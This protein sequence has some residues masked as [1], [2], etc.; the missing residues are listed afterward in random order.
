MDSLLPTVVPEQPE[1]MAV[2]Q[3]EDVPGRPMRTRWVLGADRPLPFRPPSGT[4]DY[5]DPRQ[6]RSYV[7]DKALSSVSAAQPV[8]ND[9]FELA[10]S[11]VKYTGSDPNIDDEIEALKTGRS[12]TKRL[13]GQY[14]L[15]DRATG[16][17]VAKSGRKTLLNVPWMTSDGYYVVRGVPY[18][19]VT[20]FRMNPGI[21][22]RTASDGVTEAQFNTAQGFGVPFRVR[23]DPKTGVFALRIAGHSVPLYRVLSGMGIPDQAM[24]KAWGKQLLEVNR[25]KK[26]HSSTVAWLNHMLEAERAQ[27]AKA[28]PDKAAKATD[29][30]LLR[31]Y[32]S[33]MR[34]DAEGTQRLMGISYPEVSPESILHASLRV[35]NVAAGKEEQDSRDNPSNQRVFDFGDHL[36]TYMQLDRGGVFRSA[37][38]KLRN[39]PERLSRLPSALFDQHISHHLNSSGLAQT[40]DLINPLDSF[41]QR[42][43]ITRLGEGAIENLDSAP[44][45]AREVQSGY[46]GVIDS[47]RAPECYS[48]DTDVMTETGWKSWPSV[49]ESDR[50]ACLLDSRLSFEHPLRLMSYDY[51]GKLFC[52]DSKTLS[53][54][55]TPNHRMWVTPIS[56]CTW[57][58]E[59]AE[60]VYGRN[61]QVLATHLP[62]EPA[63]SEDSFVVPMC[64]ARNEGTQAHGDPPIGAAMRRVTEPI[65]MD[66]WARFMGY[67][68]SEGCVCIDED[69]SLFLVS[70]SQSKEC[71]PE[72]YVEIEQLLA[73]LPFHFNT[74][75]A[76]NGF[77]CHSKQLALYLAQFGKSDKKHVPEYLF[78]CS[79]SN[80]ALFLDCLLKGDGRA[81]RSGVRRTLCTIS[82]Q[83]TDDFARLQFMQGNNVTISFEKDKRAMASEGGCWAARCN[84]RGLRTI[85][86]KNHWHP[87][88][89]QHI[90]DYTGKVYCAEVPGGLLFVRRGNTSGFWCGNSLRIGLDMHLARSAVKG[91]DNQ[92]YTRLLDTK[93]GKVVWRT[94]IQMETAFIGEPGST[95]GKDKFVA[96]MSPRY[97]FQYVP[98]KDVQYELLSGDDLFS[99]ISDTIPMKSGVK[100]MR[101]LMG[102]KYPSY[103]VPLVTREAPLVETPGRDG[104]PASEFM[105]EAVGALRSPVAG[106]VVSAGARRMVI[107]TD[108]GQT[109][110]IEYSDWKPYARKTHIEQTPVPKKGDRVKPGSLLTVSNYTDQDG[111]LALGRNL[112]VGYMGYQGKNFEDAVVISESAARKLT[113][114]HTY[115]EDWEPGDGETS[116][117]GKFLALFPS[118]YSKDQLDKIGPDGFVKP[119]TEVNSGDP[120]VLAVKTRDPNVTTMGRRLH[121]DKSMVWEHD[122]PGIVR[123]V[124]KTR[125]GYRVYVESRHLMRVGDKLCY[126]DKTEVLTESGWK[127]FENLQESDRVACLNPTTGVFTYDAPVAVQQYDHTGKMYKIETQLLD[128]VVTDNHK[129]FVQKRRHTAFGLYTPAEIFGKRVS[130]AKSGKW[131]GSQGDV[132]DFPG[133]WRKTKGAG[134]TWM[135]GY[136][137]PVTDYMMLLGMFLSEGNTFCNVASGSYGIDINQ[138]KYVDVMLKALDASSIEYG[139]TA[140]G[141]RI[142]DRPLLEHF[143]PFGKSYEKRIPEWV[144]S[145]ASEHLA[146]L[147]RWLI[148]GDGSVK[149][150]R[151]TSYYTSSKGLADDVQRLCLHIGYAANVHQVYEACPDGSPCG[152]I[153][154]R[155]VYRRHDYYRVAIITKKTIPT[156][157]HGHVKKQDA[158]TEKWIDYSGK[159][160]CCS[161]PDNHVIYVRRNGKGAWCGNSNAFGG[162]GVVSE[163]VPDQE[164]V[165]DGEGRPLDII[166]SSKGIASRTNPAQLHAALLGKI[167]SKTNTRYVLPG[168]F[169]EDATEFVEKELADNGISDTEDLFDPRSGKTVPQVMTGVLHFYKMQQMAEA[170]G[171]ARDTGGYSEDESPSR[172]SGGSSSKH[173]G[174]MEYSS[175]LAHGA[176]NVL[177]DLKTVHGQYNPE[178][179]R[180]IKLGGTPSVPR[181]PTVYDKFRAMVRSSGVTLKE[182]D[183]RG[184]SVFASTDA[185]VRELT[186]DR[187]ITSAETYDRK[188]RPIPGGLFDPRATSSTTTGDRFAYIALPEPL[189]NPHMEGMARSL[190][191]L[192]KVD[193]DDIV[194]GRREVDG[195]RGGE[196]L[197]SMLE[198]VD[199]ARVA[200]EAKSILKSEGMVSKKDAAAK[201]LMYAEAMMVQKKQPS[202]FMMTRV[203]VLPPKFRRIVMQDDRLVVPDLNY[204]YR[205]LLTSIGDFNE[206][207]FLGEDLRADARE[208]M[209][210]A[211][212]ALIGTETPKDK[213]L[214]AKRV[215]GV[216][217]Q[218][219]GK[220]SP[221]YSMT[222]RKVF[223]FNID[224]SALGVIVP[225]PSLKLNEVG[226]PED[227]A[228]TLFGP[229]VIRRLVEKGRGAT[230]AAEAVKNRDPSVRS[231]LTEVMAERPVLLN[232]APTLHKYG[233]MAV[234]AKTVPGKA[235]HINPQ[236]EGPFGADNDGD[237]GRFLLGLDFSRASGAVA[238]SGLEWV[239]STGDIFMKFAV[240]TKLITTQAV[241]RIC[242][243]P[244][245]PETRV[246]KGNGITEWKT[247]EWCAVYAYDPDTGV[248]RWY[249]ITALSLHAGKELFDVRI[250][251]HFSRVETVTNDHSL[252][253][254]NPETGEVEKGRPADLVGKLV[255]SVIRVHDHSE[256]FRSWVLS[257]THYGDPRQVELPLNRACGQVLGMIL[258]NGWVSSIDQLC[259]ASN[260]PETRAALEKALQV[261]GFPRTS[262][263]AEIVYRA[264]SLGKN[265]EGERTRVVVH[266]PVWFNRALGREIGKGAENKTIPWWSLQAPE[267]HLL[268]MLEG[269]LSTDGTVSL[270]RKSNG[271]LSGVIGYDTVSCYLRDAVC[272]LCLRLGLR[273]SVS[274]YRGKHSTTDCYRISISSLDMRKL[275]RRCPDFTVYNENKARTLRELMGAV[276]ETC[277]VASALDRIPYPSAVHDKLIAIRQ[278]SGICSAATL[279]S[280]AK[281]GSMDRALASLFV[282]E[283]RKLHT[284]DIV[285]DRWTR[286]VDDKDIT[287]LE[288]VSVTPAGR[289]DCWDITVPGPYTFAT[290]A[291]TVMQDTMSMTVPVSR[292]AVQ[293]AYRK[294]LPEHNLIGTGSG[295]PHYSPSQEPL[296]ALYLMTRD[297]KPGKPVRT[298]ASMAEMREAYRKGEVD[299]DDP[300]RIAS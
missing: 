297:P 107:Q 292:A 130:Y 222:Q 96:A 69:K 206:A 142:Y 79:A 210:H 238:S 56:S 98:R 82:R 218:L 233:I 176:T 37:L 31:S 144:F 76:K 86:A 288:V 255:P 35:L 100:G 77:I 167:A 246:D 114:Q 271:K 29:T 64:L 55:V 166:L 48:A 240:G 23:M 266:T 248:H 158:Q 278:A 203:P 280:A 27:Q 85:Y 103:S 26:P 299:V 80:R 173:I 146:V 4:I 275:V 237:S 270:S 232:R 75:S 143:R 228:W 181:V 200:A 294:M 291:G 251:K 50:L 169:P 49:T 89:Q 70:I 265:G 267:E 129:L 174:D 272:Y 81:D 78:R 160:W 245:L 216:I 145:L 90:R 16:K 104:T 111:R 63:A 263:S 254:Y 152:T 186:G 58:F 24:E 44:D 282:E 207:R 30:D 91:A 127:L 225:N 46:I 94:P 196:A 51:N 269:L 54:A 2:P 36:A 136:S 131:L 87:E 66:V 212:R 71:N 242:D 168:A 73:Q 290:A 189:L 250:G 13:T 88:G 221:K 234:H 276:N 45:E 191:G 61:M 102:S 205:R 14:L 252:V 138:K 20:Q 123:E 25:T 179:W 72:M 198:G 201:R 99:N 170:K 208:D 175:L 57:R 109:V 67:Y 220:G 134:K 190:L 259:L 243:L 62:M 112:R 163:I 8:R 10:V 295:R 262:D 202:D 183:R 105:G 253:C 92:L 53:Y 3:F 141:V 101:Q 195:R 268:G 108:D 147:F 32:F 283:Y 180:Q 28:D 17:V 38:W 52:A 213:D 128:L 226:V 21:Y 118:M 187:K 171:H 261:A 215:G 184:D 106:T 135:A 223:G 209:M 286:L 137:M 154:G 150:D 236:L 157:N 132:V 148:W 235:I 11:D 162:K 274:P 153:Q 231:V 121:Q 140:T 161:M 68:L 59:T 151:P 115:G 177:R 193:L 47:I 155:Q 7:L 239:T 227:Y 192:R 256:A 277:A 133:Y 40:L 1:Q 34:L 84:S 273:T 296:E 95:A 247:P 42:F 219:L 178:L 9:L 249:P 281:T 113:S 15:T 110:P 285:L 199:L 244:V 204:L 165:K 164:M 43:R 257:D 264:E 97:G 12:L 230:Y 287:W 93:T 6:I 298:F 119:G 185:D 117:R 188:M 22:T 65:A 124:V 149:G 41:N 241:V 172:G 293:E 260:V 19:F 289:Q 18:S 217:Q 83:L 5:A 74:N 156:V 116:E 125:D 159:V 126:D 197:R 194:A 279:S 211:Y 229:F 39:D 284:D 224:M 300:V 139:R 258:G 182:S 214:Q 33:R 120:L 60:N 122:E